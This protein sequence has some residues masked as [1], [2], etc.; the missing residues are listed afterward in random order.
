MI[1]FFYLFI[2]FCRIYLIYVIQNQLML[3]SV[4]ILLPYFTVVKIKK[5]SINS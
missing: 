3:S 5:Q 1:D 4:S 2:Y